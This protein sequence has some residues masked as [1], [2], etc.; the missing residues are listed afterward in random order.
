[1]EEIQKGMGMVVAE[2]VPTAKGARALALQ[3]QTEAPITEEIY[4]IIYGGRDART[5]VS[6]LMN[7]TPKAE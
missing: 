4:Q 3:T 5:A 2:G 7:R 1:M 6:N